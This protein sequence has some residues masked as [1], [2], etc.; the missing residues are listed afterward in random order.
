[1]DTLNRV[2]RISFNYDAKTRKRDEGAE[3]KWSETNECGFFFARAHQMNGD[4]VVWTGWARCILT[5]Y[6]CRCIFC[7][8][9]LESNI[10]L[11]FLLCSVFFIYF[12]CYQF[13]IVSG[14][15]ACARQLSYFISVH[16]LKRCE[17]AET[18]DYSEWMAN[19]KQTKIKMN[20]NSQFEWMETKINSLR[21]ARNWQNTR[22]FALPH[23]KFSLFIDITFLSLSLVRMFARFFTGHFLSLSLQLSSSLGRCAA[24]N[25]LLNSN[26]TIIEFRNICAACT[27]QWKKKNLLK[28]G[29]IIIQVDS[30]QL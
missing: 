4:G 12:K 13:P 23:H 2:T 11:L 22:N 8:T 3:K 20:A 9:A 10:F 7:P 26:K 28:C 6:F 1:M 30:E 25:E 24:Q 27:I 29:I 17:R 18:D 15:I 19:E 21:I 14:V 16:L 5:N